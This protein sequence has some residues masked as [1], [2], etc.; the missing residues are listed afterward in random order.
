ML[1][2]NDNQLTNLHLSNNSNLTEVYCYNNQLTNINVSNSKDLTTLYCNNNKLSSIDVT[3]NT[4]LEIFK[5]DE[6]VD[7]IGYTK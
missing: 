6:G 4:K 5:Y 2:I 3:N 7:I 1:V